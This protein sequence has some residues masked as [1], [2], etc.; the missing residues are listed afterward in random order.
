MGSVVHAVRPSQTAVGRATRP[1]AA[2]AAHPITNG[3]ASDS[4]RIGHATL[5]RPRHHMATP[6]IAGSTVSPK[7]MTRPGRPMLN[8][9]MR[10][11]ATADLGTHGANTMRCPPP[12]TPALR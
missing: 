6:K 2:P 10:S 7:A 5:R 8:S 4:G 9:N 3:A 12:G 11:T 1:S